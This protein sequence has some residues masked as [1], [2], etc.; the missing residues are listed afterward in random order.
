MIL[1]IY[2][3]LTF[4]SDEN[5]HFINQEI[6]NPKLKTKCYSECIKS[7]LLFDKHF[8]RMRGEIILLFQIFDGFF[9][10]L[11]IYFENRN[12]FL[13][14]YHV[15]LNL[16]ESSKQSIDFQS[17]YSCNNISRGYKKIILLFNYMFLNV[18]ILTNF[19]F[20]KK[21]DNIHNN[22]KLIRMKLGVLKQ[23]F[24]KV[25]LCMT[26]ASS[27]NLLGYENLILELDLKL[28]LKSNEKIL[29]F[30]E[31]QINNIFDLT[32]NFYELNYSKFYIE[33]YK[34]MKK[35]KHL[36]LNHQEIKFNCNTSFEEHISNFLLQEVHLNIAIEN[37][38]YSSGLKDECLPIWRDFLAENEVA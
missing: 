26:K 4:C 15:F 28:F 27:N 36:N 30:R 24:E 22:N 19:L 33:Q 20:H 14:E 37:F 17:I 21:D 8:L 9:A 38:F 16:I 6:C 1:F 11:D 23:I 5:V 31:L 3:I 13:S 25:N 2:F 29:D 18:K 12:L 32:S 10:Q 34:F 35:F 7:F